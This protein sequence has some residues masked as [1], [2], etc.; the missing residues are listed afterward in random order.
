MALFSK[1]SLTSP[2]AKGDLFFHGMVLP[3][4]K[5]HS[6]TESQEVHPWK[7]GDSLPRKNS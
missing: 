5:E 2:S 7:K 6:P 3:A 4:L 1:Y